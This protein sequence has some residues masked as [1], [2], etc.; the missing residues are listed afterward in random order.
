[1]SRANWENPAGEHL[2]RPSRRLAH[3]AGSSDVCPTPLR[4]RRRLSRLSRGKRGRGP[5]K[6]KKRYTARKGAD[7]ARTNKKPE[8][9]ALMKRAKGVT[10]NEIREATGWLKHA[11]RSFVSMFGGEG[12]QNVEC[13]KNSAG[14]RTYRLAR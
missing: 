3:L 7:E 2:R 6:S 14:E 4:R 11:V 5:A 9:I 1:M 10:L 13:A 8:V 12:G